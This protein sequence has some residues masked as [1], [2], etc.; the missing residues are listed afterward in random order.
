MLRII[1]DDIEYNGRLVGRLTVPEGTL[2]GH[3]LEALERACGPEPAVTY[4]TDK[5]HDDALEAARKEGYAQGL[6]EAELGAER[7]RIWQEGYAQG[8]KDLQNKP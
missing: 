6:E 3:A 4:A 5:E 7:D 2:R 8:L 1:G